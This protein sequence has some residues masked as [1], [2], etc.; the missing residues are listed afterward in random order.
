MQVARDLSSIHLFLFDFVF[1]LWTHLVLRNTD[2]AGEMLNCDNVSC[3]VVCIVVSAR[4]SF[5]YLNFANKLKRACTNTYSWRWVHIRFGNI[6]GEYV[7]R[8]LCCVFLIENL[9]MSQ[10]MEWKNKK[11]MKST[12][13]HTARDEHIVKGTVESV[14]GSGGDGGIVPLWSTLKNRLSYPCLVRWYSF[15]WMAPIAPFRYSGGTKHH[16]IVCISLA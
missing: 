2:S 16:S 6:C 8:K 5:L 7:L 9:S 12:H 15:K 13:T 14:D 4:S 1:I 3:L 11:Y 10:T